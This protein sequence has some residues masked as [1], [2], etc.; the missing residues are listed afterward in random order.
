MWRLPI[1]DDIDIVS[2]IVQTD[3]F[4][5]TSHFDSRHMDTSEFLCPGR[6]EAASEHEND[7]LS[8]EDDKNI[9]DDSPDDYLYITLFTIFYN[10]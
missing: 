4:R 10:I 2:D 1:L 8:I 3:S 7:N 9:E 5:R 6:D